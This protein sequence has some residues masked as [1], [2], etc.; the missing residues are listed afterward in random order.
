MAYT[1]LEEIYQLLGR[2]Y[3]RNSYGKS[4]DVKPTDAE[5]GDKYTAVDTGDEYYFYDDTW[6]EITP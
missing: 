3:R 2:I 1:R 4:T 6:N 5:V